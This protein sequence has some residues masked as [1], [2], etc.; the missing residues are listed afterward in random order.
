MSLPF[1]GHWPRP[2]KFFRT[3]SRGH[4]VEIGETIS[5]ADHHSYTRWQELERL[6]DETARTREDGNSLSLPRKDYMRL[7][8]DFRDRGF[9][10][11][12]QCHMLTNPEDDFVRHHHCRSSAKLS[13]QRRQTNR[14]DNPHDN[15]NGPRAR[16]LFSFVGVCPAASNWPVCQ[17]R[18]QQS[19]VPSRG[20]LG[21]LTS[22]HH[23]G[24][25]A[26][27]ARQ[28]CRKNLDGG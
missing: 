3:A 16:L 11:R 12:R 26:R 4:G 23:K 9:C 18:L 15:Q 20:P 13:S 22:H 24:G 5:F 6:L 21:P 10:L 8:F 25:D 19:A 14:K 7:P 27:L 1:A 28:Q 2:E 17:L